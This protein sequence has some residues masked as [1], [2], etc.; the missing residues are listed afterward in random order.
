MGLTSGPSSET[1][2]FGRMP[3][4]VTADIMRSRYI[5][6]QSQ[7]HSTIP[8]KK[9]KRTVFHVQTSRRAFW[10]CTLCSSW[11]QTRSPPQGCPRST[12]V[13]PSILVLVLRPSCS[14]IEFAGINYCIYLFGKS[15][16]QYAADLRGS[17]KLLWLPCFTRSHHDDIQHLSLSELPE[18][19]CFYTSGGYDGT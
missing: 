19:A 7:Y 15:K 4:D 3:C 13:L 12:S 11:N 8:F 18:I 10:C 9:A 1:N 14:C 16:F 5:S 2:L 17:S 6:I